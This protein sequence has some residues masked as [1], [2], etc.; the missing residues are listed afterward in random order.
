MIDRLV[1]TAFAEHSSNIRGVC[2]VYCL[3]TGRGKLT[4]ARDSAR[5]HTEGGP[6]DIL[7]AGYGKGNSYTGQYTAQENGCSST[8]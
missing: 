3:Q 6:M 7:A 4:K 8:V 2:G 1:F 5:S